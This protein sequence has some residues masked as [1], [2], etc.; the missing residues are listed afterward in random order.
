MSQFIEK[1]DSIQH[2][3]NAVIVNTYEKNKLRE[4]L[5]N[6]VEKFL[7][8]GGV[9]SELES[10]TTAYPNGVP[11]RPRAK[12]LERASETPTEL[13][14]K[15]NRA[16]RASNERTCSKLASEWMPKLILFYEKLVLGDKAR[17]IKEAGISKIVIHAARN[18]R[19]V[20]LEHW[21]AIAKT[22]PVFKQTD[23]KSVVKKKI[24]RKAKDP[25]TDEQKRRSELS[26]LKREAFERG[27]K[28]FTATCKN[29][30]LT[31]FKF[32]SHNE[33]RCLE[34]N[35]MRLKKRYERHTDAKDKT[36]H[37]RFRM[38]REAM[39]KAND[40]GDR[41][42]IGLCLTHGYTNMSI[43]KRKSGELDYRCV[44]C[45]NQYRKKYSEKE[46]GLK[47]DA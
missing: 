24:K 27:D 18:G 23:P 26:K 1:I 25:V 32:V 39:K 41:I 6:D 19:K 30:G 9:I 8:N 4:K 33:A 42:F 40:N 12:V 46:N 14:E 11:I 5:E 15:R 2:S 10:N 29:H 7:R 44:T 16:I 37:E 47:N 45:T 13:I 43:A 20:K 31:T 38:N 34:C 28:E 36:K 21:E 35:Q 17:F 22:I 3:R